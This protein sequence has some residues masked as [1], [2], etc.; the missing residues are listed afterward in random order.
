MTR[1]EFRAIYLEELTRACAERPQEYAYPAADAPMV[2]DKMLAAMDRGSYNKDGIAI[3]RALKRA[4]VSFTY[5]AI[6]AWWRA[7]NRPQDVNARS[8]LVGWANTQELDD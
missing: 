2:V 8:R 7:L 4:G 3:K 6:A 1:E 5:K